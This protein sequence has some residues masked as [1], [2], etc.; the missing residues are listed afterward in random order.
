MPE[1]LLYNLKKDRRMRKITKLLIGAT[2]GSV[3]V[4][5]ISATVIKVN[6]CRSLCAAAFYINGGSQNASKRFN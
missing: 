1:Q 6:K 5:F 4:L 2:V 3:G